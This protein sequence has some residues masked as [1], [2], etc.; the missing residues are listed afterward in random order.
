[1]TARR[2][3]IEEAW[4]ELINSCFCCCGVW[5]QKHPVGFTTYTSSCRTPLTLSSTQNTVPPL[6]H[7]DSFTWEEF[8][9]PSM[10]P[11]LAV[12]FP[13]PQLL[14]PNPCAP[15][16]RMARACFSYARRSLSISA[17]TI[18]SCTF[19]FFIAPKN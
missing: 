8:N 18:L 11:S 9:M 1:M 17:F 15:S 7:L 5:M 6:L 16:S 14:R 4:V 12:C 19:Q 10:S 3:V 2:T 13:E